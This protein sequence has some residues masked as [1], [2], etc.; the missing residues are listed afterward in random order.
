MSRALIIIRF[1][2]ALTTKE[3]N[4]KSF[5]AKMEKLAEKHGFELTFNDSRKSDSVYYTFGTPDWVEGY[6]IRISDH[7]Y[8][9]MSDKFYYI[10]DWKNA[11][12]LLKDLE[13]HLLEFKKKHIEHWD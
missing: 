12:E 4:S 7:Y 13:K 10:E 6:E 1:L 2:E 9:S 11:T 5:D 3:I 8:N